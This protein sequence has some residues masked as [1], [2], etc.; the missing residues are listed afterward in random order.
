MTIVKRGSKFRVV[1]G[2]GKNLGES[3]TKGG[4]AKRLGQVEW[5]K[6]YKKCIVDS[7]LVK[8]N[9]GMQQY[10]P[11]IFNVAKPKDIEAQKLDFPSTT[12][13]MELRDVKQPEFPSTPF[14][15]EAYAQSFHN[16]RPSNSVKDGTHVDIEGG[17]NTEYSPG[18]FR[19]EHGPDI[20]HKGSD[21][22]PKKDNKTRKSILIAGKRV[23]IKGSEGSDNSNLRGYPIDQA[24]EGNKRKDFINSQQTKEKVKA[25]E[26]AKR[27]YAP[28]NGP[29]QLAMDA[30]TAYLGRGR[31]SK[32]IGEYTRE[33]PGAKVTFNQ[34]IDPNKKAKKTLVHLTEGARDVKARRETSRAESADKIGMKFDEK[35]KTLTKKSKNGI[36][37]IILQYTQ[38][39]PLAA[40]FKPLLAH[41]VKEEEDPNMDERT[42]TKKAMTTEQ[43]HEKIKSTTKNPVGPKLNKLITPDADTQEHDDAAGVHPGFGV[44]GG[45]LGKDKSK[46]ASIYTIPGALVSRTSGGKEGVKLMHDMDK[47]KKKD[48]SDLDPKPP[49]DTSRLDKGYRSTGFKEKPKRKIGEEEAVS[50]DINRR[51][52]DQYTPAGIAKRVERDKAAAGEGTEKGGFKDKWIKQQ[53][54][55]GKDP[56]EVPPEAV[57]ADQKAGDAHEEALHRRRWGLKRLK[58]E[59]SRPNPVK[60]GIGDKLDYKD[61]D[62]KELGEGIKVE[63]EHVKNSDDDEDKKKIK[64]ADIAMDHLE[65]D[66]KYYTHLNEMEREAKEEDK[67]DTKKKRLLKIGKSILRII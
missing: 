28:G 63:Q 21:Y 12:K 25:Y 4:A 49:S 64:A 1:S 42:K 43:V 48:P 30:E 20:Q 47:F 60:G 31:D 59:K 41:L 51:H 35:T 24:E 54:S 27:N 44:H 7:S 50:R 26:D 3:S 53:E 39:Q 66:D 11:V 5:F 6:E 55:A 34:P 13:Q 58:V 57:R 67:A 10:V 62:E 45:K 52:Y 56:A 29:F 65:E 18:S 17:K 15:G 16:P 61:V 37:R 33:Y 8:G 22:V 9:E 19:G 40:G 14:T 2:E 36:M 23:I 46:A 38:N 32:P